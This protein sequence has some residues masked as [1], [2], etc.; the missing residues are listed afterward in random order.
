M[1][2]GNE[3]TYTSQERLT[4]LRVAESLYDAGLYKSA[5]LITGIHLCTVRK[6][7]KW[8]ETNALYRYASSLS[9][10]EEHQ[11]ASEY[12]RRASYYEDIS[13]PLDLLRTRPSTTSGSGT[14]PSADAT[15]GSET[16]TTAAT[17]IASRPVSR[18]M[19]LFN[20]MHAKK[21]DD[22]SKAR[23]SRGQFMDTFI[24]TARSS[25]AKP[26]L[27]ESAKPTKTALPSIPPVKFISATM[28]KQPS[29]QDSDEGHVRKKQHLSADHPLTVPLRSSGKAPSTAGSVA[30]ITG[31]S[32]EPLLQDLND[33]RMDYALSCYKSREYPRAKELL[34]QIPED[35][36]TVRTYLLLIQLQQKKANLQ[37]REDSYWS[38]IAKLQ[39]LALE[40]YVHM[41]RAGT[42]LFFVSNMIPKD[43]PENEWMR[44]Y[45]H[46]L[47]SYFHM[48][49]EAA[50][51][52]FTTLDEMFPHNSD[53]K[54]RLALCLR[55]MGKPVRACLM[56][57]QVRKQDPYV[58]DD[59]YH[60]AECLKEL[61]NAKYINKLAGDLLN[62]SDKHPD[63]WCV[64]ALYW[65]MK[66]ERDRALQLISRS[67]ELRPDHCGA[68]QLR[69]LIYLESSPVR[70][71]GSFREASKTEKDFVTYEGM[72]KAYILLERHLEACKEAEEAKVRMPGS[73][74]ALALYGTALYHAANDEVAQDAQDQVKEALR[75]DPSCKLAAHTLLLIYESQRR[76]VEAIELLDQQ[77]DHQPPDEIHVKKAE[78]YTT[79]ER[80]EEALSSYE[81]ARRSI[82]ANEGIANVEKILSG[83]DD[84]LEDEQ[85]LDDELDI[86][87][88]D[89]HQDDSPR[90][91]EQQLD[92][93]DILTGEEDHEEYDD[94]RGHRMQSPQFTPHQSQRNRSLFA[95]RARTLAQQ[96]QE[97][98]L[99]N[100]QQPM[101]AQTPNLNNRI[102]DTS[103]FT[104]R[105]GQQQSVSPPQQQQQLQHQLQRLQQEQRHHRH[106][107]HQE[108]QQQRYAHR[109]Q[110]NLPSSSGYPQTPSRTSF[111]QTSQAAH[112]RGLISQREREYDEQDD[113]DDDMIE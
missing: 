3:M 48:R 53:I 79:M 1:A 65:N 52:T 106:Q 30:P 67:L 20:A 74:Q 64:Q 44:M 99:H 12:F 26:N 39:P 55:W 36:R 86:D 15:T 41:L 17:T 51:Q 8:F 37:I 38:E 2:T 80:W 58:T 22:L 6:D 29:S 24:A 7:E 107:Q 35:K 21:D 108:Q 28:S 71:L 45:L 102:L 61:Y 46:G 89:V 112:H 76:F 92:E 43:S 13:V 56:F 23:E 19:E 84:E 66:G 40:A 42:P 25:I 49:Y 72:V 91:R 70:A 81:R 95:A 109:Q 85:D 57:S 69:G 68:L 90:L 10:L 103:L 88:M 97:E 4:Q 33:L 110:D 18:G 9:K 31:I 47:D 50:H 94:D 32:R 111:S 98:Q 96:P 93:D 105:Q 100:R 27:Q 11:R 73:A 83:G 87:E 63:T 113:R 82:V 59:L 62:I 75:I 34:L 14:A 60:Y 5:L 16:A 77:I 78:I 104:P 54:I 101:P